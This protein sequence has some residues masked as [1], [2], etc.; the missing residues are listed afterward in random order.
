MPPSRLAIAI[1]FFLS[2]IIIRTSMRVAVFA[3]G[4]GSN[5]QA[6]V[7]AQKSGYA[8]IEVVL[9]VTNNAE[10]GVLQRAAREGIDSIVISSTSYSRAG[11][12]ARE[13]L[14]ALDEC[15]IE[16]IA[17]AGY[18]KKIPAAIIQKFPGRI[19]NIH[20]ALLPEFGGKGMYGHHV[21]EA[22]L[23]SGTDR[24]GATVHVVD[25]GYD[26]GRIVLQREI[27]VLPDDTPETLAAR[28]LDV[29]HQL[30]PDAINMV[31]L[32]EFSS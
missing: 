16:L 30:Y 26:T 31:L 20:P 15:G 19:L 32:N 14:N 5:F 4:G 25:Q 7:D 27:P 13:L 10:A 24:T 23:R 17:L 12:F 3:S 29:E 22:V 6:I 9:C 1:G 11:E 2:D 21:H 8:A 18:M 28:V